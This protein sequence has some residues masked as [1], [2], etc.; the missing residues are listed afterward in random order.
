[1]VAALIVLLISLR[2]MRST[3]GR[4]YA[5]PLFRPRGTKLAI[6]RVRYIQLPS[7]KKQGEVLGYELTL[8]DHEYLHILNLVLKESKF[9]RMKKDDAAIFFRKV[10]R[11]M[12]E[13]YK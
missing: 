13:V 12:Q 1:M 3:D 9:D 6:H 5:N 10:E 8:R 11:I 4:Y 2:L 7:G